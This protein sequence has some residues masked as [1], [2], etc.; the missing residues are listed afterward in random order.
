MN[1][2]Y[3]YQVKDPNIRLRLLT[4]SFMGLMAFVFILVWKSQL[5]FNSEYQEFPVTHEQI[6]V[7]KENAIIKSKMAQKLIQTEEQ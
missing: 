3:G 1:N 5:M 6:K 4:V 2:L 7:K